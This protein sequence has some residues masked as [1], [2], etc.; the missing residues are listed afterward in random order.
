M[1]ERGEG[2]TVVVGLWVEGE[3][4]GGCWLYV[5]AASCKEK[6]D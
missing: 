1:V 3:V 5:W 6:S 2:E 4:F